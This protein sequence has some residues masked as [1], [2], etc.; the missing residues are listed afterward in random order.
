[1]TDD[2]L[3]AAPAPGG[4]LVVVLD[5]GAQ[6]SQL[7]ARKIRE[8][9]VYATLVPGDTPTQRLAAMS[10]RALV[11]SGGPASVYDEGA[12]T[13]TPDLFDLGVPIL[14]I[15]YGQQLMAHILGGK[16]EP[17][18]QREYG[19][20][21]LTID[22][23]DGVFAGIESPTSCWMSHGDRVVEPPEGFRSLA[24]TAHSPVAAMG[25]AE[26]RF[27]GVQFH[28]EVR[29]TPFG[30]RLLRNFLYDIAGCEGRWNPDVVLEEALP[31]IRERIGDGRVLC[32]VSGGVDS[33]TAAVLVD[34]AVGDQLT[35]MFI[36]HGL[37]RQGEP[38]SVIA[39]FTERFGSRFVA[40]DARERFLAALAGVVDPEEKRRII[41]ETFIR[42]FEEESSRLGDFQFIVHGTLQSDVIESGPRSAATIKTHHNV[43]GLPADM[44]LTNIEPF[45][46]LF[47]DE[48]RRLG[49][50]LGLPEEI[51]WRQPFPG[52]GLAIRI[53][54]EVTAE[55]LEILR[56]ADAIVREELEAAGLEREISQSFACLPII[57]S[58]GVMGDGRTYSYPIVI[59]AVETADFMTADWVRLPPEVLERIST[60]LVNEVSGVNR[61][62]YDITSKPPATIEWE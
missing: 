17:G 3:A 33:A 22:A 35:C 58:T 57:R 25:N 20:T 50:R 1:V 32:G 59:R 60:R 21:A 42:V 43:G 8:Q 46:H 24:H 26:R 51:V 4:E 10:P 12:P 47:K 34:R 13:V 30:P 2:L 53:I 14:G 62:L 52:P 39:F 23:A 5:F 38:E 49:L 29:H 48:V 54:G 11:L 15:C 19:R 28:P 37:L 31:R 55:R 18:H 36:D 61:V 27:Y 7:I 6:Y 44:R 45:R 56:A 16:V 40:V 41:G 9:G